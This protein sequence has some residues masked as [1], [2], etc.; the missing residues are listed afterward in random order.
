[1]PDEPLLKFPCEIPVK[2][3]GR[4]DSEFRAAAWSIVQRHYAE[5]DDGRVSEQ[6]SRNSAYLSLTFVV[7]A[8]SRQEVDALFRELTASDDIMVVL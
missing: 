2:V 7:P 5:V 1:M 4:N 3:L 8:Q 6:Q